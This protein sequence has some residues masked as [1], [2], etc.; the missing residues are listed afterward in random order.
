[1]MKN[2]SIQI[3][4][5]NHRKYIPMLVD[6]V[7]NQTCDPAAILTKVEP[8]TTVIDAYKSF[9]QRQQGWVRVGLMTVQ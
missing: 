5:C 3:G 9:D 4:N 8:V 7:K 1:M 6:L 2:L